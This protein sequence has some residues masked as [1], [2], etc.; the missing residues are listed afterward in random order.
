MYS[1]DLLFHGRSKEQTTTLLIQKRKTEIHQKACLLP[2]MDSTLRYGFSKEQLRGVDADAIW[3]AVNQGSKERSL[4][5]STID[6]KKT[7][8]GMPQQ[9]PAVSAPASRSQ[10][11]N[12]HESL[13][14]EFGNVSGKV[15]EHHDPQH[16]AATL[17]PPL[18]APD[19]SVIPI[20]IIGMSCRLPGGASNIEKFWE[21]ASE[22]RSAW[23][24]IPENRFNVD[25]FYHPDSDRTNCVRCRILFSLTRREWLIRSLDERQSRSLSRRNGLHSVRRTLLQYKPK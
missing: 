21:L 17:V 20:A 1:E 11:I 23:S 6:R 2:P 5:E 15:D 13:E 8:N 4:L 25:A 12:T 18:L 16:P 19:D 22:G 3:K 9:P 7:P 14:E 10:K 24:K